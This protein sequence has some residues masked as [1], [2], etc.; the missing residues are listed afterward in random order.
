MK[1][2]TVVNKKSIFLVFIFI[3]IFVINHQMKFLTLDSLKSHSEMIQQVVHQYPVLSWLVL[4]VLSTVLTSIAMPVDIIIS[5][6]SGS[7][8]G[9]WF[10]LALVSFS[11]TLG[12]TGLFLISRFILRDFFEKKF[13]KHVSIA[14]R[15]I[16]K[17]GDFYLLTLRLIPIFPDVLINIIMGLT[18]IKVM[19]FYWISQLGTVISIGLFVNAGLQLSKITSISDVYSPSL[20][21]SLILLGVLPVIIKFILMKIRKNKPTCESGLLDDL[22]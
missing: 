16:K 2:S 15:H 19:K 10:G 14:N 9:F 22:S 21:I 18:Q 5:L 17:D 4:F 12:S 7:L 3:L 11:N 6:I 20:V 1:L 8:F 13:T